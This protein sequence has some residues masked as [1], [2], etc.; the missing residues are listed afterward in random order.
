MT[1]DE[2]RKYQEKL[3][4]PLQQLAD[5]LKE[6]GVSNIMC[7][8]DPELILLTTRKL[9]TLHKIASTVLDVDILAAIMSE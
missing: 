3:D 2:L 6:M 1:E 8:D 5:T 7:Q 4:F 9:K